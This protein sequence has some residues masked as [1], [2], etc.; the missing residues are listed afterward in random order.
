MKKPIIATLVT[1]L[2]VFIYQ[3][4]SWM[5]LPIHN[6]SERYTPAQDTI[7]SVVSSHLHEEGLYTLP[8]LPAGAAMSDREA[9]HTSMQG[10][11]WM[12]L[13]YHPAWT[14]N[15]GTSMVGGFLLDL[16][17][18]A[19]LVWVLWSASTAFASF[20]ARFWVSTAFGVFTLLQSSL[21]DW[22]WL[23]TPWHYTSGDVLDHL[24]AWALSGV[25]LGAYLKR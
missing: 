6:G 12:M 25:W 10:K 5:V 18:A 13:T 16:F 21:A 22:N 11:P 9:L 3:A 24:L 15:M 7:L 17:S 2:I 1:A 19:L 23:S 4:L 14:V 8:N 20:G